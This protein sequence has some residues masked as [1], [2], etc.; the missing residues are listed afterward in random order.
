MLGSLPVP[1]SIIDAVLAVPPP[2]LGD[3]GLIAGGARSVRPAPPLPDSDPDS[4]SECWVDGDS[5]EEAAGGAGSDADGLFFSPP[6]S[7]APGSQSGRSRPMQQRPPRQREGRRPSAGVGAGA[8]HQPQPPRRAGRASQASAA[9]AGGARSEELDAD[10]RS[11]VSAVI[12]QLLQDA[13]RC[14]DGSLG[15]GAPVATRRASPKLLSLGPPSSVPV[16][17]MLAAGR[18]PAQLAELRLQAR[19]L[20]AHCERLQVAIDAPGAP[21]PG[22]AAAADAGAEGAD[23]ELSLER[24]AGDHAGALGRAQRLLV[25]S[26]N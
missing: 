15:F 9:S 13:D 7:Q 10:V 4:G 26:A 14:V 18:L 22:S 11:S 21:A 17:R 24:L 12:E 19:Q 23:D 1:A 5:A 3:D 2:P 16:S 20:S 8:V 6:A 25:G